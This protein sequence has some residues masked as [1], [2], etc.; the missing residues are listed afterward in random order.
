MKESHKALE[1]FVLALCLIFGL[2]WCTGCASTLSGGLDTAQAG[3]AA[4]DLA[5]DE[6]TQ[7]YSQAVA[8]CERNEKLP[9]CDKLG[10]PEEVLRKAEALSGAYDHT[11]ASLDALQDAVNE[12]APHTEAA[13]AIVRDAGLFAR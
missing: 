4:V 6:A 5:T 8:L 2:A 10:D 3:L 13:T 11:A 9:G 1:A 7:I 12:I